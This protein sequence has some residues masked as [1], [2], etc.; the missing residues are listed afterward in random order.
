MA[1]KW[2]KL[3]DE[4]EDNEDAFYCLTGNF[5]DW[6]ED[7]MTPGDVAGLHIVTVEVPESGSLQFRVLED[8]EADK[9][10][11]PKTPSCYKRTEAII[12]PAKDLTNRWI[13]DAPAGRDVTIELFVSRGKKSIMWLFD[14]N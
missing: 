4:D 11:C 1:A 7:R 5:N 12:G 14:K 9:V 6:G 13:I 8:G 3:M 10:I 2:E